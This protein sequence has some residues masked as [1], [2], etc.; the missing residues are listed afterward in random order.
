MIDEEILD[1]NIIYI[2]IITTASDIFGVTNPHCFN[3][4]INICIYFWE[5]DLIF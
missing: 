5:E 4:I 3:E 2:S 1:K